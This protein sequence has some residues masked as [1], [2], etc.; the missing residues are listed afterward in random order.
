MSLYSDYIQ[1]LIGGTFKPPAS[2]EHFKSINPATGNIYAHI[3][4][5]GDDDLED[6]VAQAKAAF[7]AWRATS[8]EDRA[9]LLHNLADLI[10]DHFDEFVEAE[11][12]DNGKPVSLAG[13]IDIPRG[14]ANLRAYADAVLK[15]KGPEYKKDHAESH[16][17][18]QPIGVVGVIS[19]WNLPFLLFTWKL[20]PAIAAG[21][22]V[23]AKPSEVTPMTAYMLSRLI[24][25]AGFP[26]GVINILHGRGAEIGAAMTDHPDIKAISFTGG[27]QT[28]RSIYQ[29]AA[30][31]LKKVSLELGGKNPTIIF[32]D[33]DFGR[34]LDGAVA[35]AFTNQGQICLCG[36]RLFVQ[37]GIFEKFKAA[38]V[39]KAAGIMP[40]D[41]MNQ[42]TQHGAMVSKAHMDKVLS[43]IKLA[44][45]E[46]GQ[47]LCGG[48]RVLLDGRCENGY[49]IAPTVIDGLPQ[50]CRTNREEIFGPVVALIPFKDEADVLAMANDTEYGLAASVWTAD[51]DRAARM[52]RD[53]ESG[54]V[55]LNCWNLRD[56]ETPF[57]GVKNSGVGRE[58]VWNALKF[59]SEEKTVTKPV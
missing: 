34:A 48:E 44:K 17:L 42:E 11:V 32:E 18:H 19:P 59:F 9:K 2:G 12:N 35:A 4:A 56:L 38:F 46:G 43:Y 52:A 10:D 45:D 29:G 7:P 5:S 1:N 24:S 31:H 6:A 55:W 36:S 49:F 37:E 53:L 3:P 58:G 57:G 15:F 39:E 28:G 30:K 54:I 50:A 8:A 26:D 22:C 20:A 40:A 21:N 13:K 14:A 23:I 27:T 41:P 33:A 16:V 25:K 51:K 47:I